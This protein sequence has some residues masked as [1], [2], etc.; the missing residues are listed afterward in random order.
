[1]WYIVC[2]VIM[3][4]HVE[5]LTEIRVASEALI[6]DEIRAGDTRINLE[7][8]V[9][10]AVREGRCSIDEASAVSGLRPDE[11]RSLVAREPLLES[12]ILTLAGIS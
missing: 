10:K 1:M 3:M 5:T 8:A 11:I 6:R 9:A 12:D 4:A 7:R 2:T